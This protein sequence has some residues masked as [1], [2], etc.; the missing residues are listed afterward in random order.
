MS[1]IIGVKTLYDMFLGLDIERITISNEDE[2]VEIIFGNDQKSEL[3]ST[4]SVIEPSE[5]FVSHITHDHNTK[6]MTDIVSPTVGIFER[7]NPKTEEYYVKL[8]DFVKEGQIVG[9][10]KVLGVHYDV[11]APISGKIIEI[12][13]EDEQPIEYGQPIMRLEEKDG[14][15]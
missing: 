7:S 13:I 2:K 1:N 9:Q 10:V 11:L 4:S 6:E 3:E 14:I 8:R 12:L 15:E 5:I